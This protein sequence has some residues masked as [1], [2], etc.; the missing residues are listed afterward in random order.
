MINDVCAHTAKHLPEALAALE[1]LGDLITPGK[2]R[3]ASEPATTT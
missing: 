1:L 3:R 2:Y